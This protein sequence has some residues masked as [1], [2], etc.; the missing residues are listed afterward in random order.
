M[1][2]TVASIALYG[3]GVTST[4]SPCV[5]PLV[6]GYL[7]VL[8]DSS[9]VSG[10]ARPQRVAI[11]AAGTIGTFVA[12][13]G[14]VAA[15]GLALSETQ[16]VEIEADSCADEED[17]N[18]KPETDRVELHSEQRV[19]PSTVAVHRTDHGSGYEA[20]KDRFEPCSLG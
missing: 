12:L 4:I 10:R 5:L 17:R 20:T 18:E 1:S 11:F 14:L 16:G 2:L 3:A 7:G 13:G 15:V 19:I 8:A 9:C 6:P